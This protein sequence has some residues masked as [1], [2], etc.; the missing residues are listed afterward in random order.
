MITKAAQAGSHSIKKGDIIFLEGHEVHTLNILLQGKVDVYISS[1]DYSNKK[2]RDVLNKSYK[3]FGIDKNIFIGA[4]D[5]ILGSKHSFSF[6][7]AEDCT[8]YLYPVQTPSQAWALINSQKD[9]GTYLVNSLNTMMVSSSKTLQKALKTAA[10]LKL[11]TDNLVTWFWVLKESCSFDHIPSLAFFRS[12]LDRL[13]YLREKG[14][15]PSPVFSRQFVEEDHDPQ[16]IDEDSTLP[17]NRLKLEYF[18]HLCNMPP[19]LQKSFFGADMFITS[20]HCR[21]ESE[22]LEGITSSLKETFSTVEEYYK[23]L[24]SD[25][26]ECIYSAFLK[27]AGEMA[28]S[29]L[30]YTPAIEALDY[31]ASVI[32]EVVILYRQEY[33]HKCETD[34]EYIEHSLNNVKAAILGSEGNGEAGFPAARSEADL[35]SLPDE[36]KDSAAKILEFSELPQERTDLFM[37]NLIAF[38]N[39]RD[40]LSTDEDARNI[41]HSATSVF[42][43]IYEAVFKKASLKA[44]NSRLINMFLNYGFMDEK[45]LTP[46]QTLELYK[47]AGNTGSGCK[48]SIY[49]MREWLSAIYAMEKDPS[50]NEFGQD[51]FDAFREM[52]KRGQLTEKDK[53]A[54]DSNKDS[55]LAYEIQHMLRTNHKLCHGQTS[56]YF[57][58]LHKEM[59][60]RDLTKVQITPDKVSESLAK[61]LEVDFSAFYRE[62][63]YLNANKAIEKEL[64]MK[65]ITPEIILIPIY[66]SRAAMWQEITGRSRHTPGR[67]LLP[68]FS[69][70]DLDSVMLKLVGNFRW[71]LC[72]TMMGSAW[73]DVTQSSLTSDYT[74]YIQF[75]K[76]NKDLTEEA[77]EKIKA[78]SIK[79]HGR[80]RDIFT[81]D[82]EIWVNNEAKG[83]VRLNKVARSILYK[84]C[85]FSKN[86]RI[87]MEKQPMYS[88]IA[89]HFRNQRAKTAKDLEN[90][91]GRYVKSGIPLD[92][93]LEHN[94]VFYREL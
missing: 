29:G 26:S 43:E 14:L 13:Q 23:R 77:K 73:N 47:I 70:E 92:S 79:N 9:Y 41:R 90:R 68:A 31:I 76:K 4:N 83:N 56:V 38:R 34:L 37:M 45:L 15:Q 6:L 28:Q 93:D 46:T 63:H 18:E 36:L 42:F 71:E 30:D 72:R 87:N 49:S 74:D 60:I 11:I 82:Y 20:Y 8:I 61:I 62:I 44:D 57:P 66:G 5:I 2:D 55:R 81:S 78:Q 10:S 40:R 86:I 91:Y 85:P 53:N 84:H 65:C 17:F 3:I 64:V 89:A 35:S 1:L 19:E 58:V 52:R 39:M 94:L 32:K 21:E 80:M 75:F 7:A 33:C 25:N 48:D 16:Q 69:D 24:Y 50:I 54:Y 51:Y 67:F 12:G 88:D 27:A 22:C 59:I